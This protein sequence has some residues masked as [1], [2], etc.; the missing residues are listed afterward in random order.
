[1][2]YSSWG[3]K[4]LNKTE[5]L[6]FSLFIKIK[7]RRRAT[8]QNETMCVCYRRAVQ[9][10]LANTGRF[11]LKDI[12]WQSSE[13][14]QQLGA[15]RCLELDERR[16]RPQ[17]AWADTEVRGP[18]RAGPDRGGSRHGPTSAHLPCDSAGGAEPR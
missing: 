15:N 5:R 2:G 1:M 9:V 14:R 16:H 17:T 7:G 6:H 8:I 4:E 3:C 11:L 12:L 13:Y 18:C 10:C